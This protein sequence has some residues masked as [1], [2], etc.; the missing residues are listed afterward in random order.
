MPL[1]A[2][3]FGQRA[4]IHSLL[5][6]FHDAAPRQADRPDFHDAYRAQLRSLSDEAARIRLVADLIASMPETQVVD[7]H[8]RLTGSFL[9]S[10]MDPVLQ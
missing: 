4:L 9:G 5:D 2:Q 3:R 10:A 7:L 6:V 1:A 8:H